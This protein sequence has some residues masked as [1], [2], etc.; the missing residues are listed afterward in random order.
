MNA[1]LLSGRNLLDFGSS[2]VLLHWR[3]QHVEETEHIS[4]LSEFIK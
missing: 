3:P 2:K 1:V 4:L